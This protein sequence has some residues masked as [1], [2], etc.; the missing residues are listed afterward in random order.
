MWMGSDRKERDFSKTILNADQPQPLDTDLNQF[1]TNSFRL[2]RN[3][4]SPRSRIRNE[5]PE[6]ARIQKHSLC[7]NGFIVN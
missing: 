2:V 3:C 1:Q 6:A 5:A 4:Y 7:V